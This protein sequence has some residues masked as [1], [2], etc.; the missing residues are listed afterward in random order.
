MAQTKYP[1]IICPKCNGV[2]SDKCDCCY[3]KGKL[4]LKPVNKYACPYELMYDPVMVE[5]YV[6]ATTRAIKK[7]TEERISIE[8]ALKRV[9]DRI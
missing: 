6:K 5:A 3:G 4:K 2:E 9:L 8:H 7:L 1:E